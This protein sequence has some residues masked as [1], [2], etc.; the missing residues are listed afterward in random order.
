MNIPDLVA[1][2]R[3]HFATGATKPLAARMGALRALQTGL[4]RHEKTL[5]AALYKDLRKA[6]MEAYMTELGIVYEELSYIL[7]R[8]PGWVKAKRVITPLVHFRAQ[9]FR[10]AEPYGV[11]LIVAPWNYPVQLSLAPLVGAL[12]AGNCAILKPSAYTPNTSAALATLIRGCFPA[13]F[14]AVVEGGRRENQELFAQHF[15]TIFFTGSTAV[16]KTVMEAAAR[17]LTPVSL[18]LGGKSPCIVDETANLAVAA[19]RVAFGKLLNAGQTCV[20]PD[21]LMVQETVKDAFLKELAAAFDAYL[22]GGAGAELPC[23]VNEKHYHRLLGLM[24]SGR[25]AYGGQT[26]AEKRLIWPTV[27]DGVQPDDPV[28]QEE[29]FGP[30]LPVLSFARLNEALGFVRSR[31]KPLALYLFTTSAAAEKKVLGTLSFGGGCVNDTIV[32]LATSHMPFGGVGE[33]G[34]G[35]YHGRQSFETFSHQKSILKKYNW[36][37]LPIRYHPYNSQKLAFIRRFMK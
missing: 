17:H 30:L 37:D 21:Y 9:C 7:K 6:P 1:L 10:V 33:S 14:V 18:E 16:G 32:H 12:C 29:I 3:A 34:M 5:A 28:M 23:I 2:Q 15:D 31:P 24:E 22:P 13:E 8:L 20:A 4:R 35:S 25:I 36:P 26:D 19:R 27:L 11:A